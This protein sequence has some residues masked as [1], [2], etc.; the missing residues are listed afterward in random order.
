M[1]VTGTRSQISDLVCT[2][3]VAL[4]VSFPTRELP[5]PASFRAETWRSARVS[6]T[7]LL[8][9][10]ENDLRACARDEGYDNS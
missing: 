3:V 10:P 9:S 4:I 8:L 5:M 7:R 1:A 6:A 2:L